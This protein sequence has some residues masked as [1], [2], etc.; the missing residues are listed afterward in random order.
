[1][2]GLGSCRGRRQAGLEVERNKVERGMAEL[3]AV[4]G[5]EGCAG[6]LLLWP[7][8]EAELWQQD[9]VETPKP[10]PSAL[11]CPGQAINLNVYQSFPAGERGIPLGPPCL[12]SAKPMLWL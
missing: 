10:L 6:S 9:W 1:M 7:C 11:L 2:N 5:W 12:A 4:L 8:T 3:G